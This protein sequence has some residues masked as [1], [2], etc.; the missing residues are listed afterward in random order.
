[1]GP[2]VSRTPA[3]TSPQPSVLLQLQKGF[4]R[5]WRSACNSGSHNAASVIPWDGQTTTPRTERN[6]RLS[7]KDEIDQHCADVLRD[8]WHASAGQSLTIHWPTGG[9]GTQSRQAVACC[10]I[11]CL[12]VMP[13]HLLGNTRVAGNIFQALHK[14]H[15]VCSCRCSLYSRRRGPCL[16][17]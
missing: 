17:C 12:Q 15:V 1:M 3:G 5:V 7:N 9:R 8:P 10:L 14:C 13:D 11:H 2:I 16:C 4:V 6:V